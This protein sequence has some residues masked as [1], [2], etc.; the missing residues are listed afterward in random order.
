METCEPVG[1]AE[2]ADKLGVKP[3]TVATWRQRGVG[4]P[5]PRWTVGGDAAWNW[6]DVEA[7]ARETGRL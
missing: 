5:E 1:A 4:F 6:P 3:G 2:V 7:W